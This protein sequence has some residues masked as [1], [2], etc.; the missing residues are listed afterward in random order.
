MPRAPIQKAEAL[1][2]LLGWARRRHHQQFAGQVDV[3]RA[4]AGM[5]DIDLSGFP[6]RVSR[7][8]FTDA[9]TPPESDEAQEE[10]RR[11]GSGRTLVP[12]WQYLQKP[13]LFPSQKKP[14]GL[15]VTDGARGL[16]LPHR[17]AAS[18]RSTR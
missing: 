14:P 11:L 1:G 5:K 8:R 18:S 15:M 13:A 7:P 12:E 6:T 17:S 16:E 4:M 9:L 2:D 10:T 3:I